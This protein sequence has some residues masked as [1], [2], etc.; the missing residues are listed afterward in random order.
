MGHVDEIVTLLSSRYTFHH[1]RSRSACSSAV[2]A[3]G[4]NRFVFS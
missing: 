1:V 3:G 4:R 2:F